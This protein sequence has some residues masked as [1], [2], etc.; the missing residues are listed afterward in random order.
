MRGRT[1]AARTQTVPLSV[2][3]YLNYVTRQVNI[4]SRRCCVFARV[5][6]YS[7]MGN[8]NCADAAGSTF[9][10][11]IGPVKDFATCKR[12]CHEKPHCIGLEYRHWRDGC[13]LLGVNMADMGSGKWSTISGSGV[14]PVTKVV[15]VLRSPGGRQPKCYLK[16]AP[17]QGLPPPP[18]THCLPCACPRV[19]R[20]ADTMTNLLC[21]VAARVCVRY[22]IYAWSAFTHLLQRTMKLAPARAGTGIATTW[23]GS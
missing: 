22:S 18:H 5:A 6:E 3:I 19:Q 10:G 2:V 21:D 7:L 16:P 17:I 9:A 1:C 12:L 23:T 13:S 11:Q 14:V 15:P 4:S 8:G 20:L